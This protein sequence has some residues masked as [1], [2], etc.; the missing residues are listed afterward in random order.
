MLRSLDILHGY[1]IAARD[2]DFGAVKDFLFDD[3]TWSVRYLVVDTH[4]WLPGRKVVLPPAA[5]GSPDWQEHILP[6]TLTRAEVEAAPALAEHEPVSAQHEMDIYNYFEWAPYW[7]GGNSVRGTL[8]PGQERIGEE[9]NPDLAEQ[10]CGDKH[11]Q[12]AEELTGYRMQA[13]DG[14]IGHVHDMILDD[15]AWKIRYL[16]VDTRNWIPGRK[17]LLAVEWMRSLR[18]DERKAHADLSRDE[19]SHSPRFDSEEP[20]NR[21]YEEILYDYYGRPAYWGHRQTH[22]Q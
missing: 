15:E 18:W 17:V 21:E 2:D 12:S 20:I 7:F 6:V 14:E 5:L 11:L 10:P 22:G 13:T 3:R 8:K 9:R 19:I 1:R 4:R 16:V